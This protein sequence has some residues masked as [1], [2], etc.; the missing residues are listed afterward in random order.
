VFTS[1]LLA[2]ADVLHFAYELLVPFRFARGRGFSPPQELDRTIDNV[3]CG[4]VGIPEFR[5][6]GVLTTRLL[7]PATVYLQPLKLPEVVRQG[8]P[9]DVEDPGRLLTV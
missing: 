6:R 9:E 8:D 1:W 3:N 7:A 2:S 4:H 5:V